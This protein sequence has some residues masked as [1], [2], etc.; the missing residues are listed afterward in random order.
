[1]TLSVQQRLGIAVVAASSCVGLSPRALAQ[2]GTHEL[3]APSA[4]AL[5]TQPAAD[6]SQDNK[7]ASLL[8]ERLT[9]S[10][11]AWQFLPPEAEKRIALALEGIQL[12][13][14]TEF[15]REISPFKYLPDGRCVVSVRFTPLDGQECSTEVGTNHF[16]TAIKPAVASLSK[17]LR[18]TGFILS[19]NALPP[20]CG[21]GFEF[22]MI[23]N[24]PPSFPIDITRAH[25]LRLID[26]EHRLNILEL[27][28]RVSANLATN[29]ITPAPGD[30][31]KAVTSL[32]QLR[33]FYLAADMPRCAA[34][35]QALV[36]DLETTPFNLRLSRDLGVI[37]D[38]EITDAP[39]AFRD[40]VLR[41]RPIVERLSSREELRELEGHLGDRSLG[42]VV[43]SI[44]RFE[45]AADVA[46]ADEVGIA[47]IHIM[48]AGR[49]VT[50]AATRA[51]TTD[52]IEVAG[53]IRTFFSDRF[54]NEYTYETQL[55]GISNFVAINLTDCSVRTLMARECL[56]QVGIA[57]GIEIIGVRTESGGLDPAFVGHTYNY[58]ET[59][60]GRVYFDFSRPDSEP[61]IFSSNEEI[62]A[63]Y[64]GDPAKATVSLSSAD[65]RV[66]ISHF[67][68]EPFVHDTQAFLAAFSSAKAPLRELLLAQP[69]LVPHARR[70]VVAFKAADSVFGTSNAEKFLNGT[71]EEV[72]ELFPSSNVRR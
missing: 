64:C 3:I 71:V 41:I 5:E 55:S 28:L 27:G 22:P 32:A 1:M 37:K 29:W 45:L 15:R 42:K 49:F 54:R 59:P 68:Y 57:S 21:K 8:L 12:G 63:R 60:T 38:A 62:F 23:F 11:K 35:T 18:E 46:G 65:D 52:P 30:L 70:L 61:F 69:E 33:D 39:E 44:L 24:A 58:V 9:R 56:T 13:D 50:E 53:F 43:S 17:S 6:L 31:A 10:S 66:I 19:T 48:E 2:V 67:L 26:A 47:A 25:D 4:H 72:A 7:E 14:D 16:D 40:A 51:G 36:T 20:L 34:L